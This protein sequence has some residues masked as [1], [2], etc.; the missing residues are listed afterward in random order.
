MHFYDFQHFHHFIIQFH[1]NFIVI[2]Y[3]HPIQNFQVF[4]R[5]FHRFIHP[6]HY[7]I[8]ILKLITLLK[9]HLN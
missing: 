7:L 5:T 8:E 9:H 2:I 6:I 3:Q 1:L 4:Y